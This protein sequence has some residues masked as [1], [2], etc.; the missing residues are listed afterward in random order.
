[1]RWL[2]ENAVSANN[3]YKNL[4]MIDKFLYHP[5]QHSPQT[6][7]F[8]KYSKETNLKKSYI[9]FGSSKNRQADWTWKGLLRSTPSELCRKHLVLAHS[10]LTKDSSK[11]NGL[12]KKLG[13]DWPFVENNL[14]WK[15]EPAFLSGKSKRTRLRKHNYILESTPDI[16]RSHNKRDVSISPLYDYPEYKE[17]PKKSIRFAEELD[18]EELNPHKFISTQGLHSKVLENIGKKAS[19]FLSLTPSPEKNTQSTFKSSKFLNNTNVPVKLETRGL[20]KFGRKKKLWFGKKKILNKIFTNEKL[21]EVLSLQESSTSITQLPIRN[22]QKYN[23]RIVKSH[24]NFDD[25]LSS[26]NGFVIKLSK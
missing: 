19:L 13:Y 9:K 3:L 8:I 20:V 24:K 5:D 4:I 25:Y 22:S 1:M 26:A 18:L 16:E 15:R 21:S 12:M 17:I 11:S 7:S 14:S 23:E 10:L 2:Y 6:K